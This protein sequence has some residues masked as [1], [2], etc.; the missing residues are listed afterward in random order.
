MGLPPASSFHSE[1]CTREGIHSRF[2]KGSA[3]GTLH[4]LLTRVALVVDSPSE[5]WQAGWKACISNI[6]FSQLKV[7]FPHFSFYHLGDASEQCLLSPTMR[8]QLFDPGMWD[9]VTCHIC[10]GSFCG[11]EPTP[12][13]QCSEREITRPRTQ[14]LGMMGKGAESQSAL[15]QV[16]GTVM[17]GAYSLQLYKHLLGVYY[18][19]D[20]TK[21]KKNKEM[22]SVLMMVTATV[23]L[24]AIASPLRVEMSQ[25]YLKK[26]CCQPIP[27]WQYDGL[28]FP[29]TFLREFFICL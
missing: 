18:V 2:H 20:T 9:E 29:H 4:S 27:C 11:S 6:C 1:F 14:N 19:L 25:V 24:S 12:K 8:S 26:I 22:V 7:F 5:S 10:F 28:L 16:P 13:W 3:D 23:T 17:N 21:N 15:V